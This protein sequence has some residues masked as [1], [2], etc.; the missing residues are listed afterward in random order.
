MIRRSVTDSD[1][2]NP[3]NCNAEVIAW[4]PANESNFFID[5][6]VT[7]PA[8][9]WRVR[10][11]ELGCADLEEHE[12]IS[13][14]TASDL[15]SRT[16]IVEGLELYEKERQ[17]SEDKDVETSHDARES[18]G[19]QREAERTNSSED[20][21]QQDEEANKKS[22]AK[23]KNTSE[24]EESSEEKDAELAKRLRTE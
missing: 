10:F 9:L 1:G 11:Q 2:N 23:R 12:V 3:M 18:A 24:G 20:E 4:L 14:L 13:Y 19:E 22:A 21:T 8:A 15:T 5:D 6:D 17:G 7:K 16:Q